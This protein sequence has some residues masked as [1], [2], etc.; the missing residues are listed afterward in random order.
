LFATF[1]CIYI[2]ITKAA[3]L[4][5]VDRSLLGGFLRNHTLSFRKSDHGYLL[6]CPGIQ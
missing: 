3:Y 2:R 5:Q 1:S 4:A 6:G